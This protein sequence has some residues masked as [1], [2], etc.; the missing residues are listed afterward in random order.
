[1]V[2]I[3]LVMVVVEGGVSLGRTGDGGS[4]QP[5]ELFLGTTIYFV[6]SNK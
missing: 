3:F 1:M 4:R 2:V 5:Q 6:F